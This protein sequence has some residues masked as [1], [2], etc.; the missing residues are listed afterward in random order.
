MAHPAN[1]RVDQQ[2]R[3]RICFDDLTIHLDEFPAL[4]RVSGEDEKIDRD[5]SWDACD[6]FNGIFGICVFFL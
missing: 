5:H 6:T 3:I 1:Q 4:P 2:D